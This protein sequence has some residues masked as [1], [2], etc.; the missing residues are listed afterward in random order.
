MSHIAQGSEHNKNKSS[1]FTESKEQIEMIFNLNIPSV[2]IA[3]MTCYL[4][5]AHEKDAETSKD[6]VLDEVGLRKENNLKVNA[7][8]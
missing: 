4:L 6:R 5:N 8:L 7:F 1:L 2:H 3:C